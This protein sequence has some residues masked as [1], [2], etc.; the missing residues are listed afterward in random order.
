M[1]HEK[2]EAA[3]NDQINAELY[4]GYLYLSVSA[5]FK[6][7]NLDGA[8]MWMLA[9]SQEEQIHAIKL[10]D[11]VF[12]RGGTVKLATIEEPPAE[13][14]SPLAAFEA[15]LQHEQYITGRINDLV[16]LAT[17]LK[18]HA[19]AGFLQWYVD[20]QVEEEESVGGV[21]EKLKLVSE[22]PGGLA[23]MDRELGTRPIPP[24]PFAV[25]ACE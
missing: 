14:D 2:M 16:A 1:L 4:S 3:I 8:A 7:L 24:S 6:S 18:D 13:W 21:V 9:Q 11:Y 23:E 20:E 17:E 5:Y 19:S 15:A 10:F 25:P 22:A 12:T